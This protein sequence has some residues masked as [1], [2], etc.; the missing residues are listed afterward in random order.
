[1]RRSGNRSR[2]RSIAV[3][4][5][6]GVERRW[7]QDPVRR[8]RCAVRWSDGVRALERDPPHGVVQVLGE[9]DRRQP[10]LARR[11]RRTAPW[12]PTGVSQDHSLCAWLSDGNEATTTPIGHWRCLPEAN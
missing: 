5:A 4:V 1:M 2:Q 7:R 11:G 8:R 6:G 3:Q 9:G 12:S 10:E